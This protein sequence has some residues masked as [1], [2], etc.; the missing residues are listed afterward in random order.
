[1]LPVLIVLWPYVENV[2]DLV[3][4]NAST[5][6]QTRSHA[7]SHKHLKVPFMVSLCV[8]TCLASV[9]FIHDHFKKNFWEKGSFLSH[10]IHSKPAMYCICRKQP[11]YKRT[12]NGLQTQAF[13]C[14]NTQPIRKKKIYCANK[15]RLTP[16]DRRSRRSLLKPVLCRSNCLSCAA[17]PL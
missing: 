7:S 14:S 10:R 1:M 17:W 13:K 4:F 2:Q 15:Q 9:L 16:L 5:H 6:T 3:S 12:F 8:L 11:L